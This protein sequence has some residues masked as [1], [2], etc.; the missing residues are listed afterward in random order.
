MRRSHEEVAPAVWRALQTYRR[1]IRPHALSWYVAPEGGFLPLDDERWEQ[2]HQE[3]LERPRRLSLS[4]QLQQHHDDV[5]GY[6]FEY[7]G[8]RLD[9]PLFSRDGNATCAVSF[10]LPTEYL[11]EQGPAQVRTLAL[12]LARELPFSF[13]Y[14]SLALITPT[15]DW[16]AA[17][18]TVRN[19]R[20]RYLGLD[21]YHLEQT[22]R[23]LGTRARGAYWLTF[24]GQPL[25]GQLG[26]HD[27][28]R[29]RLAHP[30][31]STQPLDDGRVLLTLSEW[32]EAIDTERKQRPS[33]Q[34]LALAQLLEPFLYEQELTGWFFHDDHEGME[35]M[36]CWIRRLLP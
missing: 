5:G 28:P 25:L 15:L 6:N 8:R 32:P 3:M 35:D 12:E 31:I 7:H 14:A 33:P 30:D 34:L 29:Q 11:M 24:L 36:R 26:G 17:R 1:A 21:V 4:L 19:L 23:V 13:G 10:T 18:E 27:S 20:D 2:A 16:Y 22:S 9:A